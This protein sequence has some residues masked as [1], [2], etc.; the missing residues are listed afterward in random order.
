MST[1]DILRNPRFIA[2]NTLVG[3]SF[4]ALQGCGALSEA[5]PQERINSS[6][7]QSF[8]DQDGTECFSETV[9]HPSVIRDLQ[10]ALKTN[11]KLD[12]DQLHGARNSA[13]KINTILAAIHEMASHPTNT[14]GNYPV[15]PGDTYEYC[16]N[17]ESGEI[18]PG[19]PTHFS[20]I[21]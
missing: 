4:A 8:I 19:D 1:F 13:G 17:E 15:Q 20:V 18:Q 11:E 12:I 2:A 6:Y 7:N 16:V 14:H 9:N 21:G 10:E 5:S 3:L